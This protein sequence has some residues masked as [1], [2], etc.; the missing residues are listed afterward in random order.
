VFTKDPGTL[1]NDYFV[2]L[3]E[4]RTAWQRSDGDADVFEGRDRKIISARCKAVLLRGFVKSRK[5][6]ALRPFKG[7]GF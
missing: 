2:N 3:L 7:Y 6:S 1:S 4:M 5:V